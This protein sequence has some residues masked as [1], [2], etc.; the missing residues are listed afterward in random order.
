MK[1]KKWMGACL[2]ASMVLTQS[3]VSVLANEFEV[4]NESEVS[5]TTNSIQQAIDK[6]KDG[7]TIQ[8]Q[9]EQTASI[10]IPDSKKLTLQ[11]AKGARLTNEAGKDTI[12]IE[13][14]ATVTI[15][16]EGTIQNTSHAKAALINNG[17]VVLDGGIKL[18][19]PNDHDQNGSVA[20]NS[21]Y[22]V[23]NYGTMTVN[24][25]TITNAGDFSSC[26]TNGWYSPNE[27][28][29]KKATLTINDGAY[30]EGGVL[31]VKNDENGFLYIKGGTI[32]GKQKETIRNWNVAE[33]S[34]G[35]ITNTNPSGTAIRNA[36][37]NYND[38]S[39]GTKS[40][41]IGDLKIKG[42]TIQGQIAL[43][44]TGESTYKGGSL[45]IEGGTIIGEQIA[46]NEKKTINDKT[47]AYYEA[48]STT[49]TS[50]D[51]KGK[52][53]FENASTLT[54][55]GG[56]FTDEIPNGANQN[57]STAHVHK[58]VKVS[59]EP[60]CTEPGAQE[61]WQCTDCK[62][63]FSDA[64]GFNKIDKPVE[65]PATGHTYTWVIDKEPTKDEAGAKYQYC[66]V[67]HHKTDPV[68]IPA[69]GYTEKV[70][71]AVYR[72]YN[73]NNGE[74]L[75]TTNYDEFMHITNIGWHDEGVSFM[76]EANK[77][78]NPVYRVYNPNSGLH[79]YTTD[80]NEKN[81]LVS[82]GWH[83]EKVSWYASN[84]PQS[85]PV[86]RV[87]NPNGGQHHYTMNQQEKNAL[88]SYGWHDEGIAFRTS[89]VPTK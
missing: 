3:P 59:K 82:L 61:H 34:G 60:T 47:Q 76:T 36:S 17:T 31:S 79:H 48:S 67:C 26:I 12:T 65:I 74:H 14:G 10:S 63:L 66:V 28:A 88:V 83:D 44:N 80:E 27:A 64:N 35:T 38:P 46:I 68:S 75:Y 15:T 87:Y 40:T 25:A 70:E 73:P 71:N 56:T 9:G 32:V 33:I 50:G 30:I 43:E 29:D 7:D 49:I 58:I 78:G 41:S 54:V 62:A 20:R 51:I 84:K 53:S 1:M 45:T 24:H 39:T 77:E 89:L 5:Q 13:K 42:G 72:A 8:I 85:A 6:A 2:M 4:V 57:G 23:V 55:T 16:G 37:S 69:I 21:W 81:T 18:D 86:F 52:L 11:F 19:R 22:T